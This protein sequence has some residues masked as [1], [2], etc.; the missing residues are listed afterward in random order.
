MQIYIAK[1][2]KEIAAQQTKVSALQ[3]EMQVVSSWLPFLKDADSNV[4]YMAVIA[5]ERL[6]TES[7]VAPLVTALSDDQENVRNRAA[8]ALGRIANRDV[9]DI[10]AQVLENQNPKMRDAAVQALVQIG[11][12]HIDQIQASLAKISPSA[13]KYTEQVIERILLNE[14]ALNKIGALQSRQLVGGNADIRVALVGSGVDRSIPEFAEALVDEYNHVKDSNEP[15]PSTTMAARLIIGPPQGEIAG[16]APGVHL[17]S[18]RVLG[19]TGGGN[20]ETVVSGILHA[21]RMEANIIYLELGGTAPS[22]ALQ[23]AIREAHNAGCLVIAAAGNRNNEEKEYPAAMDHV[24][25]VAATDRNDRK[26]SYSSYGSWVDIAAPGNP[27]DDE[28][29]RSPNVISLKGTSFAGSLV[30][31]G[32]ALVWSADPTLRNKEIEKLLLENTD[33]IDHLNKGYEQKLGRGRLNILKAVQALR[34]Q[35]AK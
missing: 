2:Q 13:R 5:L 24:I 29:A 10:V 12:E 27:I 33:P 7:T 35:S 26:A 31:G 22:H 11:Y 32:A 9:I 16:V 28:K 8:A 1:Q 18:E 4:R 6:G 15:G 3:G 14:Y 17:I 19:S 34:K 25:A 20:Y 23:E 21:V 30:A